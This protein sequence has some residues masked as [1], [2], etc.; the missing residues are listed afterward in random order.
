MSELDD[1]L[2]RTLP[3]LVERER[4]WHHGDLE[5][6]LGMWSTQDPVTLFGA[7]GR[8]ASGADEIARNFRWAVSTVIPCRSFSYELLAAGVS[9][10]LA[11]TVGHEHTSFDPG[12]AEDYTLRVTY[13]YRREH[14]EWRIVHRH[15][16][17][18]QADHSPHAEPAG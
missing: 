6:R 4:A 8:C 17:Y 11:Y 1:F 5:A 14:G 7:G 15:G 3:G 12:S 9:G 16:D 18:L 2:T 13:I 10:D